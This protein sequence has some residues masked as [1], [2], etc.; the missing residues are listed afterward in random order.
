VK[1]L[2]SRLAF[3]LL[4]TVLIAG[5]TFTEKNSSVDS[6]GINIV[7][8]EVFYRPTKSQSLEAAPQIAFTEGNEQMTHKFEDM[9]VEARFQD[10]QFEGRA[11]YIAVT[12]LDT[13]S[14][15]SRQLYQF[16]LENPARNQFIG[17]HGFTGLNYVFHPDSPA[18]IQYFCNVK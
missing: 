17:D 11:L 8:C 6:S 10:D 13:G 5:C 14:E 16:D 12:N 4:I 3:L 1:T 2:A 9:A 18:E 7:T 15:I